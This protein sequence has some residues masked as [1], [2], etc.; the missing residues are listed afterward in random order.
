M[1]LEVN[2]PTLKLDN[3]QKR[4]RFYLMSSAIAESTLKRIFLYDI[5]TYHKL[6]HTGVLPRNTELIHGVVV[7]K[8]TISP[9]LRKI[10]NKLRDILSHVI[11]KDFAILQE[12]PI[13]IGNSEPEPDISVVKGS[14]DDFGD[15]HPETADFVIEVAYSSLDDDLNKASIYASAGIPCYWIL[16][17]QNKKIHVF[18]NPNRETYESHKIL[19]SET[20]IAIPHTDKTTSLSELM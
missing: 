11:P 12:S 18:K 8:M 10:V 13:T 16:D 17:L 1:H 15:K 9:I 20:S 14:Y 7:Y 6:G 2:I 3:S 5:E 19:D 4:D